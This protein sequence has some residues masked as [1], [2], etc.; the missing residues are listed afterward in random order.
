MPS[1]T[2]RSTPGKLSIN[3]WTL[4][5][6]RSGSTFSSSRVASKTGCKR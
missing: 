4:L 1:I 3:P 6:L 5:I 2:T